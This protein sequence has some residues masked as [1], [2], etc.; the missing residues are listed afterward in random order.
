MRFSGGI[1]FSVVDQR[2]GVRRRYCFMQ[3]KD[4]GSEEPTHQKQVTN[5]KGKLNLPDREERLMN[6]RLALASS[7]FCVPVKW[8]PAT[9]Q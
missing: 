4:K 2:T 1:V 3:T 7:H 6:D 9:G 8:N 5:A